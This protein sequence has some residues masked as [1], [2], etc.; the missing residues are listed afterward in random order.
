MRVDS[1]LKVEDDSDSLFW[2]KGLVLGY[3][4][5]IGLLEAVKNADHFLHVSILPLKARFPRPQWLHTV[6]RQDKQD[7]IQLLR[8]KPLH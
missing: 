2:S 3:V 5:C 1:R 8:P 7:A 4:R 6:R